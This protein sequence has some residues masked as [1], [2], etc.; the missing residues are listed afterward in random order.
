MKNKYLMNLH[1]FDEGEDGGDG[2]QNKAGATF[3]YE[4][5]NEIASSRAE[6]A[7]KS[8]LKNY[9][10]QAGLSETEAQAAFEKYKADKKA[11]QPNVAEIEADRDSYK[12][13]YEALQN[14]NY[15]RDK[16]VHADEMEFVTFKINQLVTDKKNFQ[17]AAD[18]FLKDNPKYT[19]QSYKMSGATGSNNAGTGAA[20]TNSINDAIRLAARR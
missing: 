17:A 9:F 2:N 6:R 1:L 20:Q 14:T 7:E 15:L 10:A 13:K 5:L 11:Q 12:A 8:A 18:E 4:Q 19:G 16:G 3:T